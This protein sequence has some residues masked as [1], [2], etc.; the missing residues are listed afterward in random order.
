MPTYVTATQVRALVDT[1]LE[2]DVIDELI[3]ETEELMAL[4]VSVGATAVKILRA[5]ARTWT[6][7]RIMQRDPTSTRI[8][9]F[10]EDRKASMDAMKVEYDDMI[11]IGGGGITFS[12]GEDP[13][14]DV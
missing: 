13:I 6:A 12:V 2:D 9:E 7:H 5:I 1:K 8:G 10:S 11:K 3:E 14:E 4:K